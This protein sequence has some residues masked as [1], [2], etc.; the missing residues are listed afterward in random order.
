MEHVRLPDGRRLAYEQGGDTAGAVAFYFHGWP[1]SRIEAR[2]FEEEAARHGVRVVA[3][4][5]PGIGGSDPQSGRRIVDWPR[6][7]EDAAAALGFERYAVFG[8]SAA[9]PYVAACAALR[10]RGLVGAAMIA[11]LAPFTRDRARGRAVRM[12]MVDRVA[13]YAPW[14]LPPMLRGMGRQAHETP[15]KLLARVEASMPATDREALRLERYR[16]I[17]V[18]T[19]AESTRQGGRW[20][21]LEHALAT[22]PWGFDLS[23]VRVPLALFQGSADTAVPVAMARAYAA[24]TPYATV[25]EYEG[26]GHLSIVPRAADDMMRFLAKLL[27]V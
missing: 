15:E 24:A 10:P 11:G 9:G 2:L 14:M 3:L 27:A 1:G 7:V 21:A 16:L 23:E 18:D 12:R 4:D 6:D 8:Y 5:R 19:I 25:H 20:C 17:M 13:R 22:R 26:A